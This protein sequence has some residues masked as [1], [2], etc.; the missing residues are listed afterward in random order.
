MAYCVTNHTMRESDRLTIAGGI[1][2]VELMRRAAQAIYES[3]QWK[4]KIY[5]ICGKGNNGGD[6]LALA[7]VMYTHG[8]EPYVFLT[9]SCCLSADATYYLN[10]LIRVKYPRIYDVQTCDFRCDMLVDCIFGTGFSGQ[11]SGDTAELIRSINASGAYVVSADIP[12]G[13]DGDSGLGAC[14]V[15][16]DLTVAVQSAKCGHFLAD[17]KDRCGKL[18]VKEIGIEIRGEKIE[19]F[20]ESCVRDLMPARKNNTHKGTYGRAVVLGGCDRYAGAVKLANAGVS[21]LR[22]GTGLCTIAAPDS[23]TAALGA[24]V[25]ENTLFPMPQKDGKLI[26]DEDTLDRL[27]RGASAVAVG[28]GMGDDRESNRSIVDYFLRRFDG[29][30]IVDADGLNALAG[31][32]DLLA[33]AVGKVLITPHPAEMARLCATSVERILADPI[34]A[35]RVL[36]REFGV[37]V[38]LKGASSIVTDGTKVGLIVNGTPALAK[39]GSGDVLSGVILGFAAQGGSMYECAAAGGYLCA[40][41]ARA[42]QEEYGEYGVLAADVARCAAQIAAQSE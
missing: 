16:A 34:S 2:S 23:L 25:V 37:T 5:I 35:A 42:A 41:A 6:G 24:Y 3:A 32:T 17:G 10:R 31:K 36:A 28:M 39:G 11:P 29:N 12:S 40:Q 8:I 30:L 27:T 38:L 4:G 26:Y 20:D 9:H 22:A 18:V 14:A 13:L 33:H 19:L 1:D 15:N 7:D 21:A